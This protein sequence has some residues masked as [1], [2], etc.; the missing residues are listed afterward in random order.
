M[1]TTKN[2]TY[3]F[4]LCCAFLVILLLLTACTKHTENITQEYHGEL[5]YSA[6]AMLSIEGADTDPFDGMY[7]VWTDTTQKLGIDFMEQHVYSIDR[8][9]VLLNPQWAGYY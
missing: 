1:K 3:L 4:L 9:V 6:E 7:E 5:E 2:I 8:I